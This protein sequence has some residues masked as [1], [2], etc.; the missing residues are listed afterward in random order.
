MVKAEVDA[1]GSIKDKFITE[2]VE[3]AERIAPVDAFRTGVY[4]LCQYHLNG[5]INNEDVKL[6]FEKNYQCI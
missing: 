3:I 1:D 5:S 6:L 4:A 2:V